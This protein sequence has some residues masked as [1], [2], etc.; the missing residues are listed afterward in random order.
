MNEPHAAP[1]PPP[2]PPGGPPGRP[3]NAWERRG[4]LGFV[5]GL[6]GAVKAFVVSPGEAFA[7]T[8][9]SGDLGSPLLFAI[10]LA[11][12]SALIGQLWAM[13]VGTSVLTMLPAE[14]Q[15]GLGVFMMS[16]GAGVL[17]GLVV[18]PIVTV[19][20]IFLWGAI[21]HVLLLLVGGLD[22]SE[23]GFEGSLRVVAY[24]SVGN[25]AKV[26]PVIGGMI[27]VIW[28]IF[29]I[30]IGLNK[31]HGTSEG[32]AV[33]AV[34]LPLVVCCVC[35]MGLMMVGFGAVMSQWGGN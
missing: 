12:V 30:V 7:Q 34:I 15:Q 28:M 14:M 18:I 32:K 17:F 20:W 22:T 10:L 23:A 21:V 1:P 13:V 25:L 11:V 2:P 16:S 19:I 27:S 5:E 33:A 24:S 29:L 3:G 4:E 8:R 31:I 6:L 26:V 35:I 9:T